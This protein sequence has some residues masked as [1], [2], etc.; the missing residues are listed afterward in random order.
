MVRWRILSDVG[1]SFINLNLYQSVLTDVRSIRRERINTRIYLCLLGISI[2]TLVLYT[3]LENHSTLETIPAPSNVAEYQRLQRFYENSLQCLCTHVSIEYKTIVST[4]PVQSLHPICT[5]VFLSPLWLDYLK[6]EY[7]IDYF[8]REKDFRRWGATFFQSISSFCLLASVT[9]DQSLLN[10]FSSNFISDRVILQDQFEKQINITLARLQKQIPD[11]L[12]Q[13]L[14]LI[15]LTNQ[16][17]QLVSVFSSGWQFVI[18]HNNQSA[19]S[20]ANGQ[21]VNYNNGTC[22]CALSYRCS[23]EARLFDVGGTAFHS[24]DGLRFGCTVLESL[25]QSSLECFYS[26]DCLEQLLSAMPR[27]GSVL[28]SGYQASIDTFPPMDSSQSTFSTNDTLETIINRMFINGW[29]SNISYSSFFESCAPR[30]CSFT[31]YYRFDV[32]N[33]ITTFLSVFGGL[34]ISFRFLVPRLVTIIETIRH[35]HRVVHLEVMRNVVG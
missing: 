14:Q 24:V 16:G 23:T 5:S 3:S 15:R 8:I 7:G 12:T 17:N 11:A 32:L 19:L 30:Q 35:R 20:I 31:R 28:L 33:V 18:N 27:G 13:V 25:L 9:V 22:S 2:I 6:T 1:Q 34:S 4:L 10:F 21:P 26:A 29:E